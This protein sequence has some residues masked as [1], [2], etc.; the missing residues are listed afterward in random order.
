[1]HPRLITRI[2]AI[3]KVGHRKAWSFNPKD[4]WVSVL[5]FMVGFA[6]AATATAVDVLVLVCAVFGLLSSLSF[7]DN[8]GISCPT[9]PYV[10]LP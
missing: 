1:M 2:R 5:A 9:I 10:T 6:F 8:K 4:G 7:D 3:S